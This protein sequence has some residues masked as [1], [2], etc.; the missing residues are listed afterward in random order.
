MYIYSAGLSSVRL[1]ESVPWDTS[2]FE[3]HV[4]SIITKECKS[5]PVLILYDMVEQHY[6]KERM[7]KVGPMDKANVLQ[8]KLRVVF[9]QYTVRAAFRLKEKATITAKQSGGGGGLYLF[10]AIPGT[11]NFKRVLEAV[12]RSMASISGLCLLPVESADMVKTIAEKLARKSGSRS[13]WVVFM[14]QHQNGGLRQIVTKNGELALTR[15]TPIVDNDIDSV[16]WAE[17][18]VQEFNAT[19]SYLS[20]FGYSPDDGLEVVLIANPEPGDLVSERIE[21][22]CHFTAM[23]ASDAARLLGIGN[24]HQADERYAD[25]LHAAWSGSKRSFA[26]PMQSRELQTVHKPRQVAMVVMLLMLL[27]IVY[28]LSQLF[29]GSQK[30]SATQS[31]IDN[32]TS[33]RNQLEAA[34]Q[35][36]LDKKQAMGFDVELVQGTLEAYD[37]LESIDIDALTLFKAIGESIGQERTIDQITIES[38]QVKDAFSPARPSYLQTDKTEDLS[39]YEAKFTMKLPASLTAAGANRVF[40]EIRG[41]L[42]AA[43]PDHVVLVSQA[44]A[45]NTYE[46]AI[47]GSAGSTVRQEIQDF[48]AEMTLRKIVK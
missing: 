1:V 47:E 40:E 12:R 20:R 31:E 23:A 18:V 4:S 21:T 42:Q 10:A 5:R 28:L 9:P 6:R 19:M 8:R 11:E 3:D 30:L 25:A 37:R 36:E 32:L 48:P 2:G 34:Y 41:R 24:L 17:E 39:A 14:G 33:T 38:V 44:P 29:M 15:M 26:L 46:A 22:P 7:P 45:P 27:G 43:L 13:K 35:A 16:S